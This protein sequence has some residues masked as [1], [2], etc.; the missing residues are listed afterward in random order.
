MKRD[1]RTKTNDTAT[2]ARGFTLIELLLVLV[3]L[4]VLAVIVVPKFTGRSEQART[5]GT[6]TSLSGIESALNSFEIDNGR[7]P[8]SSEGLEA[9]LIEPADIQNDSWNGPYLNRQELPK[10]GW[11][12][13][14]IYENPGSYNENGFDLYSMGGDGQAGTD[15]DIKNWSEEL[16]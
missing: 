12:N 13:E 10:D 6:N 5:T 9:L 7:F 4:A 11:G 2:T 3:I 15:D 1:N 16:R 14:F 8:T